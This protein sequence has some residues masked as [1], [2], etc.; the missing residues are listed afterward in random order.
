MLTVPRHLSSILEQ[1]PLLTPLRPYCV[2]SAVLVVGL[3]PACVRRPEQQPEFF[4]R[5]AKAHPGTAPAAPLAVFQAPSCNMTAGGSQ[6]GPQGNYYLER[7]GN[8]MVLLELPATGPGNAIDNYWR[9]AHNHYFAAYVPGGQGWVYVLPNDTS[10]PG[11]RVVFD[12]YEI[13]PHSQGFTLRG[14]ALAQCPLINPNQPPP[15]PPPVTE[16]EDAGAEIPEAG[17]ASTPGP[18]GP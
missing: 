7:G 4:L 8:G 12:Q 2:L 11:N 6:P 5:G 13:V 17:A 9:D 10:R 14:Q 18:A 15:A 3:A 16:P 1:T